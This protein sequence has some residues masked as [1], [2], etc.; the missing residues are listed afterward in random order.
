MILY[1]LVIIYYF[2]LLYLAFKSFFD[3]P[4][5][6]FGSLLITLVKSD[7]R[8]RMDSLVN[9]YIILYDT[10]TIIIGGYLE[11]HIPFR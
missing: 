7:F 10:V 9:K 11:D 1:L 8:E 5:N 2:P 6:V 4:I 3:F